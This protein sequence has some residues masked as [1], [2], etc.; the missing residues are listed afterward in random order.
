M[1]IA[2]IGAGK[3]GLPV[4]KRLKA[5]SHDV[6]ILARRPAQAE[7]LQALGFATESTV[8][9]AILGADIVFSCVSDDKALADVV[10]NNS[11]IA[12][13]FIDMST[14]SPEVSA[15]VA[16]HLG[17]TTDYLRAPV[18]GSTA[19]AESG[20][21]TALVSGPKL[22]F[23]KTADIFAAFTKKAFHVGEAEEAR[24]LKLAINSMVCATSALLAEALA[25][26]AKGGLSHAT[27]MEVINQSVVASP[28]IGYKTDMIVSGDYKPAATLNTLMK[29]LNLFLSAG[30]NQNMALP[31]NTQIMQAY[32]TASERGLGEE[33][34]FV[35]IQQAAS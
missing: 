13:T 29:D 16:N 4:C 28:L 32:R 6:R 12:P 23:D 10:L 27:M 14:V 34:F 22:A 18:S 35:L 20:M 3:M 8:P 30:A 31:V 7:M 21:L 17:D 5:S 25:F 1:K 26:G 11:I 15:K 24:Y 33:D 19:L 9:A 2:W